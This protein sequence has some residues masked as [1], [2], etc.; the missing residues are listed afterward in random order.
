MDEWCDQSG[1]RLVWQ[2]WIAISPTFRQQN[3]VFDRCHRQSLIC[4]QTV[5]SFIS[6]ISPATRCCTADCWRQKREFIALPPHISRFFF[7]IIRQKNKQPTSSIPSIHSF[8]IQIYQ[9]KPPRFRLLFPFILLPSSVHSC[10]S[11]KH[12]FHSNH[13]CAHWKIWS[14]EG[15]RAFMTLS[16]DDHEDDLIVG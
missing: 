4:T 10:L 6:V 14:S 12:N 16:G 5:F 9:E 1:G 3:K 8:P 7:I 15:V 13:I 11:S 2:R